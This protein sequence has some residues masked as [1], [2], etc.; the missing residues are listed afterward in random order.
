ME[1]EALP[2]YRS[3]S[4]WLRIALEEEGTFEW[5]DGSNPRVEQ[6]HATSGGVAKDDIPW[7]ASFVNW[8]LEQAGYKRKP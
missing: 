3:G 6:Y 7:C 5:A 8:C 4:D 2:I 1:S